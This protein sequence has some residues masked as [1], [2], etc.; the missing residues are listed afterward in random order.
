MT[1]RENI[2]A[3]LRYEKYERIPVVAFGYWKQTVEKW[4]AEG[5]ITDDELE[6]FL[7]GGYDNAGSRSILN[8]LGF[9]LNWHTGFGASTSLFPAFEEELL[10]EK[11]DGSRIIR[12]NAGLIVMV[13]PGIVSIPAEVGT[14]LTGREAWEEHYLPRFQW[15]EDRVDLK[16]LKEIAKEPDER[17]KPFGLSC[18]SMVGTMRN[19]LGV[20]QF[21]Y[22]YADDI[23]LFEE[24][25]AKFADIAYRCVK[26]ALESGVKF[27]FAHFWEDI[28]FKTGPLLSPAVF[29]RLIAPGYKR[30]TD[31]AAE[32]GIDIVSLDCDGKIDLLVPIW[33]KNGVNT[34]FPIEVGTW[35]GSIEPWREEY[36]K[37]ILGIGGMDKRAFAGDY[38]AVDREIERLKP[39]IALGGFIPCPD[40]LIPPDAKFENIQYYCDKIRK[41]M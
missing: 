18:G 39:L 34:M 14:T 7:K 4:V 23:E 15:S 21:S 41:V 40:H 32:Y 17:E 20:E 2:L 36:G 6:E 10:E 24:I 8:K 5:H 30:I 37:S 1:I 13:K 3:V 19:F 35:G 11:P 9:D 27:D 28:C 33:L 26:K 16:L 25:V 29:E 12:D 22:L 31:L 38:A